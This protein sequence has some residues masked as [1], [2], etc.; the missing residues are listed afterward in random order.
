MTPIPS[1]FSKIGSENGPFP[2]LRKFHFCRTPPGN[3]IFPFEN[4][5]LATFV[6]KIPNFD[7]YRFFYE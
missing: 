4:Q 1:G 2:P 6:C 7:P 3:I 5:K